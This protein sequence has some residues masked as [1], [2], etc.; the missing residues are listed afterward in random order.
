MEIHELKEFAKKKVCV[1][2]INYIAVE[3]K[4]PEEINLKNEI[5]TL[6]KKIRNQRA[7]LRRLNRKIRDFKLT[8]D[9]IMLTMENGETI[10]PGSAILF[11]VLNGGK[12]K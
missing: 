4:S 6:K 12:N 7:E 3:Y 2:G 11:K 10:P 8:Y 9:F 1:D 5:E